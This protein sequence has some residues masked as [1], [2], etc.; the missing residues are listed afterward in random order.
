[1][2]QTRKDVTKAR[3]ESSERMTDSR[4]FSLE[5]VGGSLAR[6]P[7]VAEPAVVNG[8][9]SN[10]NVA[11]DI[12]RSACDV[13]RESSAFPPLGS[14]NALGDSNAPAPVHV[15]DAVSFVIL[16]EGNKEV[17]EV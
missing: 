17:L 9:D 16:R 13:P 14:A 10:L 2:N 3:S 15:L 1:M 6:P 5:A 8:V 11:S 4:Q 7:V 12:A